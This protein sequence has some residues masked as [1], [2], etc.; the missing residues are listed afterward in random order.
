MSEL[1]PSFFPRKG[2]HEEHD[3]NQVNKSQVS[4]LFL[5]STEGSKTVPSYHLCSVAIQDGQAFQE[6]DYAG[7]GNSGTRT[8][9]Y[10]YKKE[11]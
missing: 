7:V 9:R 2:I 6:R 10:H 11:I 3:A 5:S 8:M 1:A 4:G